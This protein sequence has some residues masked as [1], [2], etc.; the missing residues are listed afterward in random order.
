MKKC[1]LFLMILIISSSFLQAQKSKMFVPL[2][3]KKAYEGG[4]R[5]LDGKP[6][7]NYWQNGSDYK[8]NA[9]FDPATRILSGSETIIYKNNSPNKLNMLVIRLYQDYYRKEVSRD[10]QANPEDLNDGT[11]ITKLLINGES[12]EMDPRK[13]F[14]ARRNN[15]NLVV[16]LKKPVEAKSEA[17]IEIDWSYQMPKNSR[18]RG[19]MYGPTTFFVSYWYPQMA[20]YDDTDGWDMKAYKGSVEFYND[21][22]NYDVNITVPAKYVVWA[23]GVLQNGKE[24]FSSDMYGKVQAAMKS[25]KVMNVITKEDIEKGNVT[26]S[27][28]KLTWHYKAEHVPDFVFATGSEML[29]DASGLKLPNGKETFI[30]SIYHKDTKN[31]E[32]IADYARKS[33]EHFS[34]KLPGIP[35][36]Y[37]AMTVF[38]SNGGGGMEYP[39]M[40][41]DGVG[42]N[43]A[44]NVGVTAHEIAHTYMPFYMGINE[45]KYA[46]M[47][48]G[49]AVMLTYDAQESILP[50]S[51][52]RG[53]D[54][55]QLSFL[56]GQEGELPPTIPSDILSG[57]GGMTYST[58]VYPRAGV[59]YDLLRNVLGEDLFKKALH[60]YMD[61]WN[62]KHPLPHDFF[63]TFNQVAGEDLEWFWVPWF[64]ERGYAEIGIKDVALYEGTYKTTIE[65]EGVLP[66]PVK[67]K[68]TFEDGTSEEVTRPI[69]VWKGGNREY[70]VEH[71]P[72]KKVEK[73]ELGSPNIPDVNK[74]N[75]K[76]LFKSESA[77]KNKVNLKDYVGVYTLNPEMSVEVMIEGDLLYAQPT[78][79]TRLPLTHVKGDEFEINMAPVT[80]KFLRDENKKVNVMEVNQNGNIMKA[81]KG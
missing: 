37:P 54:G 26:V 63:Y 23:T 52:P 14:A 62:G 39:M 27:S 16:S 67:L 65:R 70:V 1:A 9:E 10:G 48:E 2:N 28:S 30:S 3:F 13:P 77:E 55:M 19:G 59:A 20:V 72:S 45:R 73:I 34:T 64:Y 38:N 68:Y 24:N 58:A 74:A 80:I 6:G 50:G 41:N 33:I 79:Q 22:C 56:M 78:G 29:W 7:P 40:V 32:E 5:T 47:D 71:R 57:G 21:F 53:N 35:Y 36:P 60:E 49:W 31:A 8:I 81:K 18:M 69:T 51:N 66:V 46:F 11:K 43:K 25:D 12:V 61:R 17:K 76:Y 44:S 75:N 4:T 42:P 15:T